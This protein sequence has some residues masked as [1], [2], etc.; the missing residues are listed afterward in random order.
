MLRRDVISL[1]SFCERRPPPFQWSFLIPSSPGYALSL[2]ELWLQ[3]AWNAT[4]FHASGGYDHQTLRQQQHPPQQGNNRIRMKRPSV[5]ITSP[6][7]PGT[8]RLRP[9]SPQACGK[10]E[11]KELGRFF[12]QMRVT[13][14]FN[15]NSRTVLCHKKLIFGRARRSRD[16]LMESCTGRRHGG[17]TKRTCFAGEDVLR[18]AKLSVDHNSYGSVRS[19]TPW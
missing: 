11:V 2:Y 12:F 1:T 3:F 19:S 10:L 15:Q 4:S 6:G 8:T 13:V 16:G 18:R 5:T 9:H 7:S 14:L 17:L